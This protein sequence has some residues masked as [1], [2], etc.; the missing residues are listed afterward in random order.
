MPDSCYLCAASLER[1]I[2]VHDDSRT[3]PLVTVACASC[4]LVQTVPHPTPAEVFEYYASGAYRR[5][6][7]DLPRVWIGDDGEPDPTRLV[8]PDDPEYPLTCDRHGE[9]AARRL[10]E[11]LDLGRPGLRVLEV[12]GGDGRVNA[13]MRRAGVDAEMIERDPAKATQAES[14]G[15]KVVADGAG[16]DVVFALQVVEHFADPVGEL[17]AMV[18]RAKV[19]GIVFVEV[20][21]VERP[22]VSLTHFLQKPH[23]VNYSSHTLA[24]ALRCAGL[25]D[26][27]T[28]IDGGVLLGWGERG[29]SRR[30][31][32]EPHG[33]PMAAEVVG[34]LHGW[35]RERAARE[36][37]E[38][39]LR[40]FA[41]PEWRAALTADEWG[42]P[43]D[44][45]ATV[46]FAASEL[47]RAQRGLASAVYQLGKVI[48]LL[49][50]E[51]ETAPTWHPEPWVRGC[52]A[53]RDAERQKIG[54]VLSMVHSSLLVLLNKEKP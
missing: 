51:S 18:E 41:D 31:A 53:G 54:V 30:R 15:A 4:S 24:E 28:A 42:T 9:H 34:R 32:Y 17:A 19:G 27:R 14:L 52:Y 12:G 29:T 22:Y 7:P 21:T 16:Y 2:R 25:D 5:E 37:A 23:V 44:S 26:V 48:H 50:S 43:M 10:I 33:G 3:C 13:A 39:R 38:R 11:A 40:D 35:E 20:P 6:F 46:D 47:D 8:S 1:A 45:R 49:E 36:L